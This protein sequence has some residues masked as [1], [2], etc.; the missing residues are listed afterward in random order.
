MPMKDVIHRLR[1]IPLRVVLLGVVI[2]GSALICVVALWRGWV[3][4]ETIQALV[5]RSGSWGIAA[6]IAGVVAMELL[7]MPRMWGLLAAGVLFGP[8]LG[9]VL[10]A[11]ADLLGGFVCYQLAK[12]AG[13]KWVAGILEQHPR[14]NAVV[15]LLTEKKG[16]ATMAFLR[17]CPVA[18]YTLV[19][20]AAGLTSVGPRAFILGTAMGI[21]PGAILI[22][23]V[24]DAALKPGSPAFLILAGLV[25]GALIITYFWA[26]RIL[27]T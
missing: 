21:L 15:Q 5:A 25:V 2:L 11:A 26:R 24:G 16:T 14:T 3:N 8:Y 18:H 7:W 13:R 9:C 19:S 12:G 22:P 20:Y 6:F 1:Q 17:V 4:P 27:K 10:S 23:A